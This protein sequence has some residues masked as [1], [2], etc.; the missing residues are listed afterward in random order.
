MPSNK[1]VDNDEGDGDITA[2]VEQISTDEKHEENDLFLNGNNKH[3]T[4]ERKTGMLKMYR[5]SGI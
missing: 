3:I 5:I 2:A 1:Q 4:P